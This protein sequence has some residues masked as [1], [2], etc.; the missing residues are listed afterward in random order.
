MAYSTAR[1]FKPVAESQ[2]CNI[3]NIQV[4]SRRVE[5]VHALK[6]RLVRKFKG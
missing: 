4:K 6:I 3:T 2:Q 5:P 1:L